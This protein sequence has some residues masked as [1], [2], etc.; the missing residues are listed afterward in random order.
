MPNPPTGHVFPVERA[1]GPVWYMKYCLLNGE[2][3]EAP[4]ADLLEIEPLR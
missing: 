2:T 3:T 1:S 4:R